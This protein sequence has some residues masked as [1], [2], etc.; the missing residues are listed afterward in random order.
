[1]KSNKVP[2]KRQRVKSMF[3]DRAEQQTGA[4]KKKITLDDMHLEFSAKYNS[5]NRGLKSSANRQLR[6]P[7]P[8]VVPEGRKFFEELK[9]KLQEKNSKKH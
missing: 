4:K 5:P 6:E 8:N 9:A 1:M 7:P 3:A 2:M